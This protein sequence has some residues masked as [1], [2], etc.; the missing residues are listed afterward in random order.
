MKCA[1][2]CDSGTAAWRYD[3]QLHSILSAKRENEKIIIIET[4]AK[5]ARAFFLF[6]HR[7]WHKKKP[8]FK[9]IIITVII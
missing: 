6:S 4:K 8:R 5:N 9:K 7:Y 2:Q 3:I 1:L